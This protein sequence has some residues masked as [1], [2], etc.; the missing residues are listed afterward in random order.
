MTILFFPYYH[1]LFHVTLSQSSKTSSCRDIL[2]KSLNVCGYS[3]HIRGM[4]LG[5]TQTVLNK[6]QPKRE[7]IPVLE[8]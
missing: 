8:N 4:G 1:I 7:K 3:G 6:G 5:V 2:S